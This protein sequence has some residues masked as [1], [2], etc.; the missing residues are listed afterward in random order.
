MDITS[1]TDSKIMALDTKFQYINNNQP[2]GLSTPLLKFAN[3]RAHTTTTNSHIYG[4]IV[5]YLTYLIGWRVVGTFA[6]T[7]IPAIS[8]IGQTG[9]VF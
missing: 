2:T 5:A 4:S 8:R 9:V 1:G 3:S 6:V 7:G